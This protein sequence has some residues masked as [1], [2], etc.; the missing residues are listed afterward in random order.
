M[1]KVYNLNTHLIIIIFKDILNIKRLLPLCI[2]YIMYILYD[3]N[4]NI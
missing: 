2:L 1:F 4:N 3:L